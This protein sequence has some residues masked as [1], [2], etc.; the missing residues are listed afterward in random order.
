MP[1]SF[2]IK[3]WEHFKTLAIEMLTHGKFQVE[4]MTYSGWLHYKEFLY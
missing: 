2:V 3:M 1:W 4:Q